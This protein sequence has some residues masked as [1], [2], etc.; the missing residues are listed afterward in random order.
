MAIRWS[1]D[2]AVQGLLSNIRSKLPTVIT[3]YL[4]KHEV[5]RGSAA[6]ACPTVAITHI[7]LSADLN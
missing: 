6:I 3:G 5:D 4:V 1:T 2:A 7:K